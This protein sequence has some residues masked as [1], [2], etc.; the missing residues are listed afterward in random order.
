MSIY[1]SM[2]AAL[3][4]RQLD[5]P[6]S[7]LERASASIGAHLL[8]LANID[9][10][11][12]K[13]HGVP[14]NFRIPLV[15][16]TG[17]GWGK[18][19]L[20]RSILEPRSGILA[21]IPILPTSV[22]ST[23]SVESWLGTRDKDGQTDGVFERYKRGIVA[24]D[25]YQPLKY[26]MEG[27]G[28]G[29]NEIYLMTA[30][31]TDSATKDLAY[32]SIE[33]RGIGFTFW[34]GMRPTTLRLESGLARRFSFQTF[35]PGRKKARLYVELARAEDYTRDPQTFGMKDEVE[36]TFERVTEECGH[37]LD[38]KELNDFFDVIA[39]RDGVGIPHFEE[40]IYRRLAIGL[41]VARGTF[42]DIPIDTE[43]VRLLENEMHNRDMLRENV[44][45]N[46][47]TSILDEEED[48]QM[49]LSVLKRFLKKFY[50]MT[51]AEVDK[52]Y[53]TCKLNGSIIVTKDK[54]GEQIVKIGRRL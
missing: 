52:V 21:G 39:E 19:I 51:S 45:D 36:R 41:S 47:L 43:T 42:P 48:G 33:V 31:D 40:K 32:G 10:G 1:D 46:M 4:D 8:N 26:I 11:G 53:Y 24:A 20:F 18:S 49:K 23:F 17:S 7:F 30:L 5:L 14:M 38:M 12:Y 50:Q 6:P 9:K 34:V 54:D 16:I 13:D 3:H 37:R 2:R 29:N 35:F 25:D 28:A 27:E 15:F 44:W 22:R